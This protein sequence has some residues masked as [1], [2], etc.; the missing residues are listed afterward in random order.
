MDFSAV[1]VA[2]GSGSRAGQGRPKQWMNLGGKPILRW[3]AQALLEAGAKR[4]VVVIP[5]GDEALAAEV[6]DG[7]TGW[8]TAPGGAARAQSVV[9]GLNALCDRPES[10]VV[11]IHDAAR[12][13][14]TAR[15][16]DDLL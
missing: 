13:F 16:I 11:L 3:S 1:I 5:S 8:T 14:L 4:L 10:E 2:A 7:L 12:P 15:H 6:L 9:S